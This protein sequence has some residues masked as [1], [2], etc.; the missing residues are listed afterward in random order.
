MA[1]DVVQIGALRTSNE[2]GLAAHRPKGARGTVNAAG[3]HP[4][5]A[6]EGLMALGEA[7]TGLGKGRGG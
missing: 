6:S 7:K 2:R 5:G 1:V 3:N 4:V